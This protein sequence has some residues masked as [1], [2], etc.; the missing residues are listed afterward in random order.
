M[1]EDDAELDIP[2]EERIYWVD[3]RRGF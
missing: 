2:D 3:R 1:I